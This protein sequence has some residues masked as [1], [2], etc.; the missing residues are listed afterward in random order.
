MPRLPPH[1]RPGPRQPVRA[2]GV[3]HVRRP[4]R[5]QARR[6][7]Q[8]EAPRGRG[9]GQAPRAVGRRRGGEL[10]APGHAR[11]R[12]R[13][14]VDGG[15]EAR[16]GHG[17]LVSAGTDRAAQGLPRL[18]R[19]GLGPRWLQPAHRLARSRAGGALRDHHRLPGPAL[20]GQRPRRGPPLPPPDGE[21]R[22][23]RREP[24][25]GGRVLA[26]PVGARLRRQRACRLAPGQPLRARRAPRRLSLRR[27][28]PVGGAGGLGRR[29]LGAPGAAPSASTTG[30]RGA[31]PPSSARARGRRRGRG[32]RVGVDGVAPARGRGGDPA[33]VG[34]RGRA[35]GR[36]RRRAR[37]TPSCTIATTSSRWS[38]RA[39]ASAA[40]STTASG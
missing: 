15:R 25:R 40:T 24:G 34:D 2:R 10:R 11:L 20:R 21:G 22:A 16:P 37:P 4:Q 35:R 28:G 30:W 31:S 33:G 14:R 12:P 29:R 26:H 39:W 18:R 38:T 9:P 7:P 6:H 1:L 17:E 19:P 3:G 27:R 32:A 13:L 23:P 8:P 5:G 36:P